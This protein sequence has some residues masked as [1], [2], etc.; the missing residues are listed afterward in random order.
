MKLFKRKKSDCCANQEWDVSVMRNVST[1]DEKGIKILGSGCTKCQKLEA[2]VRNV[3]REKGL[4]I[5]I[6]H[7]R[8][9]NMI[10]AYGI[11]T[12]PALVVDG[13]VVSYGKIL[14]KEEVIDILKKAQYL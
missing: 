11:M 5:E 6:D 14:S 12:T 13:C 8:D 2:A 10:A 4:N 7:V 3:V 1:K 9:F